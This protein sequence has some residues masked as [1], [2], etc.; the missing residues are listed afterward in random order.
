MDIVDNIPM[1]CK[2]ISITIR[3][4]LLNLVDA[5]RQDVPRSKFIARA[6][7]TKLKELN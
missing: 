6:L 1:K 5:K 4:D 7:E 2:T 3:N